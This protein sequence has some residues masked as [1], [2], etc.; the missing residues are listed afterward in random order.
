MTISLDVQ[1]L[2]LYP[3]VTKKVTLDTT[4]LVPTGM[5]GDE[6]YMITAS[7]TA[8][9]NSSTR[10][11]I[12]SL[13]IASGKIGWT[14]SSGFKG[15]NGK[16]ALDSTHCVLGVK[17]DATVSGTGGTGY[18][19][20]TL[21]H[22]NGILKRGEDIA[23]DIQTKLHA[24][25]VATADTGYRL[26]YK[27][28]SVKFVDNKFF[29]SSGTIANSF[30]GSARSSAKVGG[31]P[32]NDCS[33]MLGFDQQVTTEDLASITILEAPLLSDY[34]ADAAS[35]VIN[36]NTGISIGDA[37]C[38]TDGTNTDYFTVLN[39]S[40]NTLTVPTLATNGFT[41]ITHSYTVASGAYIQVL[42]KGDP[43][44]TP[45]SY[46]KDTDELLRYMAK[47]MINQIDFS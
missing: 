41:G 29:I 39:V 11:G 37:L 19:N 26:A 6:K 25:T 17:L 5:E 1:N 23:L 27:N 24:L 33:A 2:D 36:M 14:K 9:S 35:L 13:Y 22:D 31:A 8:Y 44:N 21:D 43:D 3:G 16:F 7:T 30:T 34:T 46:H 38:I 42:Q 45:D 47:I 40:T 18:Y 4:V 15:T 10:T 12:Q 32:A 20:I 28:C